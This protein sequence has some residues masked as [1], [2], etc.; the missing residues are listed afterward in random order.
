MFALRILKLG[1]ISAVVFAVLITLF[2]LLFPSTVRISRALD[3]RIAPAELKAR[4]ADPAQWAAWYPGA[5]SAELI[6]E[7]GRIRGL[8]TREGGELLLDR[9]TDSSIELRFAGAQRGRGG[10][11]LYPG[12]TPGLTTLQWFNDFHLRWYPW[13]K[14]S[15]M[16]LEGRYGPLMETGLDRLRRLVEQAPLRDSL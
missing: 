2:S 15:G 7:N 6:R 11:H 12:Q 8:R 3:I 5:D 9:V 10:W 14:F 16:L 4:L 13:E 1:L